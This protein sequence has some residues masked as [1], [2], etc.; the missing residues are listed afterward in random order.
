MHL[1]AFSPV[2][3]GR[4][5]LAGGV[6]SGGYLCAQALDRR[7]TGN[8][9]DDLLLWGGLLSSVPRRQRA[10][11]LGVHLTLG[12]SLAAVYSILL[13]SL[14]T[15]PGPIRGFLFAQ[16]ENSLAYPGVPLINRIHPEVRSGRLPR[17]TTIGY[18]A[19]ETWR[20]A[21]YGLLLGALLRKRGTG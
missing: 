1:P 8:E 16:L 5:L 20:H 18:W 11:G 9:Y 21:V 14:P 17:L 15:M 19:A 3:I 7:L 2:Q 10:L 4:V 6:A 13:P 12:M